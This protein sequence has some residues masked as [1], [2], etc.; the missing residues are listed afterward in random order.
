MNLAVEIL[1]FAAGVLI[2]A[3]TIWVAGRVD[4]RTLREAIQNRDARLDKLQGD[5]ADAMAQRTGLAAQLDAERKAAA[6]KLALIDQAQQKLADTFSALSA[7]ALQDNNQSF[8]D[9][10]TLTLTK[11]QAE[12]KGDLEK[13][14]SAIDQ[15]LK[16]VQESLARVDA[17]IAEMEKAR[18]GAYAALSEQVKTLSE[19]Q[20]ALQ[21][22]TSN[23]VR[24]LRTPVV[25]GRWGEI[26]LKRVVEIAGMLNHCDFYEQ[27]TATTEEGRLRPDLLI[28][29]PGGKTIVVDAK[30]PLEAYLNSLEAKDDASRR[31][32]LRVHAQ[33]VRTHIANLAKKSYW[34][35][36]GDTAEF[37]VMFL[38]GE[39][40]FSAAL[41]GD[42]TLIEYGVTQR[43]IPASPTTLIALLRAVNYGW[44]QEAIAK[45]AHQISALGNEIY[46]RLSDMNKHF[47]TM[48]KSLRTAVEAYNS[49]VGSLES[50]VLVTARKFKDHDSLS[51][52]GDLEP[53]TQID[54]STR[55]LSAQEMTL[56]TDSL[57]P[58]PR[59]QE[60]DAEVES[61]ES[62]AATADLSS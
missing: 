37:V 7:R 42:P 3:V 28:R 47:F 30:A 18:S 55:S 33:N 51:A 53:P 52:D 2:G 46:K 32:W 12:A 22:E 39:M 49:A 26:Q 60:A 10:A 40:F 4:S 16:P 9:L 62:R 5:L 19:G 15:S 59:S 11:Y 48:G 24:A 57:F 41:E 35:Q 56:G 20:L 17:L 54:T 36:F 8:L 1:L 34:E 27:P 61:D 44:R 50:R 45:E 21:S 29:Q 38:P 23:L 13:R 6:E 25:R 58:P 31:D 43:V 14:Q